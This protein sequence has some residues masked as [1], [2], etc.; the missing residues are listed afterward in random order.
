V[1]CAHPKE[2]TLVVGYR[3]NGKYTGDMG[4]CRDCGA[5]EPD[6]TQRWVRRALERRRVLR[7]EDRKGKTVRKEKDVERAPV[8]VRSVPRKAAQGEMNLDRKGR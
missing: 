6:L 7:A 2:R 1:T 4:M 8:H 5:V 3:V